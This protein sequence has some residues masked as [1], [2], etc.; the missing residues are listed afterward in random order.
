MSI[1][2]FLLRLAWTAA[3]SPEPSQANACLISRL[4]VQRMWSCM[5]PCTLLVPKRRREVMQGP[6]RE[7]SGATVCDE[8]EQG[9]A[10]RGSR[11]ASETK[12]N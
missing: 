1:T 4:E 10:D 12:G 9:E 3:A 8:A 6:R 5:T 2:W 11:E 7:P